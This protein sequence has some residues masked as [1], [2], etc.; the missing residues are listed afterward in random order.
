M[1]VDTLKGTFSSKYAG[2][3][4]DRNKVRREAEQAK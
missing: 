4:E 2:Q 1:T 3:G